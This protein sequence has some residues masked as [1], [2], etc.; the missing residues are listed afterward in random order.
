MC[1][2]VCVCVCERERERER[3]G[4]RERESH[5]GETCRLVLKSTGGRG[6]LE[7]VRAWGDKQGRAATDWGR[8][9][10]Q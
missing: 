1:V 10:L 8:V 5:L 6:E 3:E 7:T 4:E 2:C 9:K